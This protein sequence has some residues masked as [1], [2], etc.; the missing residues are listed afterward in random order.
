MTSRTDGGVD[1]GNAVDAGDGDGPDGLG[2]TGVFAREFDALGRAVAIG[3]ASGRVISVSFP[4]SPPSDTGPDHPLLDRIGDYLAG[5][6]DDFA[7]VAVAITV[8]T[9]QREVLESIRNV[10]YGESID[11]GRVAKLTAGLDHEDDDDLETVRA[12]LAA[13]PVPLVVPDHRVSGVGGATPG[14]LA[15]RLRSIEGVRER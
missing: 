8:P 14:S 11:L 12:A 2:D 10:P 9:D 13:N 1:D 7:D 5:D 4:E 6:E 3:V 15:E